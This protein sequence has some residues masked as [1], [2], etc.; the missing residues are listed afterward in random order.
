MR[1]GHFG[2]HHLHDQIRCE[3]LDIIEDHDLIVMGRDKVKTKVLETAET[4]LVSRLQSCQNILRA[5]HLAD[6]DGCEDAHSLE[7]EAFSSDAQL[8]SK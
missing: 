3:Q 7:A 2:P 6:V 1:I 8:D 4:V 5:H